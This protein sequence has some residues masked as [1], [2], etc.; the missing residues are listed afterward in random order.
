MINL[1]L[2]IAFAYAFNRLGNVSSDAGPL[3]PILHVQSATFSHARSSI[4]QVRKFVDD[5]V[6]ELLSIQLHPCPKLSDVL[7]NKYYSLYSH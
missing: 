5:V 2:I 4:E 3:L 1:F 6:A 7:F